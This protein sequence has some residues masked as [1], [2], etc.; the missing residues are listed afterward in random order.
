MKPKFKNIFKNKFVII[1]IVTL[2]LIIGGFL[3]WGFLTNWGKGDLKTQL[4]NSDKKLGNAIAKIKDLLNQENEKDLEGAA[5]EYTDEIENRKKILKN[6]E[7]DLREAEQKLEKAEIAKNKAEKDLEEAKTED[8]KTNPLIGQKIKKAEEAKKEAE[9]NLEE[10]EKNLEEAKKNSLTSKNTLCNQQLLVDKDIC[11]NCN[12][13]FDNNLK[14]CRIYTKRP[15]KCSENEWLYQN[16]TKDEIKCYS[17]IE[18]KTVLST[19]M[20]TSPNNKGEYESNKKNYGPMKTWRLGT[21]ITDLIGLF[22][23]NTTFNKD[24][25]GWDVSN[26][27]NMKNMFYGA[28]N[29]DKDIS[30]WDVSNVTNMENM[31]RGANSFNIDISGW[32]VNNVENAKNMFRKTDGYHVFNQNLSWWWRNKTK[33]QLSL[34]TD[35]SHTSFNMLPNCKRPIM[36]IN[37]VTITISGEQKSKFNKMSDLDKLLFYRQMSGCFDF[38]PN[39]STLDS[40]IQTQQWNGQLDG[41]NYGPIKNWVFSPQIKNLSRLFMDNTTFNENISGWNVSKVTNMESM[42][43]KAI[44]FNQ[45]LNNWNVSNVRNMKSMFEGAASFN[46]PLNNWNVSKVLIMNDMFAYTQYNRNN[47]NIPYNENMFINLNV[48]STRS[49]LDYLITNEIW[50]GRLGRRNY[51]PIKNWI[52]HVEDL[53]GLFKNKSSFN[54]DISGWDVSQ[55][56]VMESMFSGATSFNI[57]ISGWDVSNVINMQ[58]MFNM[59]SASS[60]NQPLNNWDVSNVIDMSYM[61]KDCSNMSSAS[62]FNQPLNNWDVSNVKNMEGMFYKTWDFNQPLNNWDVSKVTNMKNM[63]YKCT[64]FNG[65]ISTWNVSKVTNM[66][67]MFF[68][69]WF[70]DKNIDTHEVTRNNLPSYQAWNVSNVINMERMFSGSGFS[71]SLNKWDVSNVTNMKFMFAET[72][73]YRADMIKDWKYNAKVDKYKFTWNASII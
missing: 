49:I 59:G 2:V 69:A 29:F 31:F 5:T 42:F 1:L 40:L 19:L 58:S 35:L 43:E 16:P 36:T 22:Q 26:V 51:G 39:R 72:R 12:K 41:K 70:F 10:A 71:K 67:Y 55:V 47:I 6:T 32:N 30:G 23:N 3:I 20:G 11:V 53:T 46:Q 73:Y 61:F 56:I 44:S 18:N 17:V 68:V 13:W 64:Y 34:D 7:K 62:S 60:F 28:T 24:I 27:T 48:I 9:K 8:A 65:D 4:K 37:E 57:D 63:F 45:P 52:I 66:S 25:S 21:N 50:D 33:S 54:T 14:S 15:I 38:I